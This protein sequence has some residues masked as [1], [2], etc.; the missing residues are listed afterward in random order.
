MSISRHLAEK[1]RNRESQPL[2]GAQRPG[3]ALVRE[4]TPRAENGKVTP[5]RRVTNRERRAREHLTPQEVEKLIHAASRVGR[6]GH[7]DATLILI[8]YRHGL[9]VSELVALRWEQID[10]AQGL[11]HISRLKNGVPST[12]PLRGPELRA[13]RRLRR[14]Q[15]TSPYVVT[16]ERGTSMT[17]SSVRKIIARAGDEAHLGFPVHPHMLRHACGFKLANEGHDTRAIQHYLGHRNI[18]HTVRYTELA[19]DRF[20]QFWRD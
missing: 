14:E 20:K 12:H 1:D 4:P 5:P 9:R 16:S 7:R 15:G 10:F 13:L 19:A 2:S 17:N 3:L 8:A 11:L 6:Y 18:Q